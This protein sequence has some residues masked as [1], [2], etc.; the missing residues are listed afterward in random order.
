LNNLS[1][2]KEKKCVIALGL[3]SS[4]I[5]GGLC[6]VIAE[7]KKEI[8]MCYICLMNLSFLKASITSML[9]Q[10]RG[11]AAHAGLRGRSTGGLHLMAALKSCP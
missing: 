7:D 4:I 10:S 9:Q 2:P 11:S 5:F 3:A 1:F 6:K 8:Y